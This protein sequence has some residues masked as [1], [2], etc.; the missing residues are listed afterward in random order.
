MDHHQFEES[1]YSVDV[2]LA[3]ASNNFPSNERSTRCWYIVL[4][5]LEAVRGLN[6]EAVS[7][8]VGG[9]HV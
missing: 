1:A 3:L 4:V 2:A 9:V 6:L 7:L 8:F 5:E